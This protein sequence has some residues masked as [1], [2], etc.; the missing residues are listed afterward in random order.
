MK[1]EKN[2]FSYRKVTN[3]KSKINPPLLLTGEAPFYLPGKEKDPWPT[4]K[5]LLSALI[6]A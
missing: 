5:L 6:K 3:S 2:T 1:S 4:T